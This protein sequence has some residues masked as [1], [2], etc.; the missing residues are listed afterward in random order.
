MR[1]PWLGVATLAGVL[2]TAAVAAEPA[3][4]PSPRARLLDVR[5]AVVVS[6]PAGPPTTVVAPGQALAAGTKLTLEKGGSALLLLDDGQPVQLQGP[7]EYTVPEKTAP[8]PAGEGPGLLNM[9]W[10]RLRTLADSSNLAESAAG[11]VRGGGPDLVYPIGAIVE[12]EPTFRWGAQE[13]SKQYR[14]TVRSLEGKDLAAA[15]VDSCEFRVPPKTLAPGE[16]YTWEVVPLV[17][18]KPSGVSQGFFE[19]P[20]DATLSDV[21]RDLAAIR[22]QYGE[23]LPAPVALLAEGAYLES[24]ELL[25]AALDAYR[26]ALAAQPEGKL[27]ELCRRAAESVEKRLEK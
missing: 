24:K 17:A 3:A 12:T 10:G 7:A 23:K 8:A 27:A 20:A 25:G 22:K 6:A 18:S 1:H 21:T 5:G 19:L 11:R 26:R 13:S 14:V 15:T 2:L 4:V 9:L 16:M